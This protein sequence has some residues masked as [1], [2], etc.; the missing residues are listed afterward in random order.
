MR[1]ILDLLERD[2][3]LTPA[4]IAVRLSL[5]ADAVREAIAAAERDGVIVGYSALV[6]WERSETPK[7][8]AM[9]AVEA[10]PEHG[11]GFDA[12]AEYIARFDE[13]HSVYLMSGASDLQVVVEGDDFREI[14]RFVAEKLAVAPGVRG[15]ATSFVLKTYKIE[16]R[17]AQDAAQSGRLAVTP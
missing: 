17:L 12:V 13:V 4:D 2:C 7:V 11:K 6:N 3:R 8:Y 10:T 14:A 16:G 1:E 15:T 5:E 9:I